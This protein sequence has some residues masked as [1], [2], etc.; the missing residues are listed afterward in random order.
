MGR[1]QANAN[2]HGLR[3][4]QLEN[5]W[6]NISIL[7]DVGAKLWYAVEDSE[8][9]DGFLLSFPV[10]TCPYLWLWL[11]YGGW[12]GY[13][14]VIVEPWTGYPVHLAEAVRG[15]T[16]RTLEPDAKFSAEVRAVIY[17]KGESCQQAL[18]R[19]QFA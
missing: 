12:R 1:I 18:R 15:G 8:T 19:A 16:G 17:T 13:H 11:V 14:H 7:P 4:I 10:E 6:L 3:A 2:I 5:E 9:G